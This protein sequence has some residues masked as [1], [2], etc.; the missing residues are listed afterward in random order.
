MPSSIPQFVFMTCRVGAEAALK[1]E[2]A[3]SVPDWRPAFSR[4][5][6]LTFK[7]AAGSRV[8]IDQLADRQWT[9]AHAQGI[10]L[11][12]LVGDQLQ[13]LVEQFWSQVGEHFSKLHLPS[14]SPEALGPFDLHVW[15]REPLHDAGE[16]PTH[17]TPLCLEIESAI[18]VA[19]PGTYALKGTQ[20]A[21]RRASPRNS[22]VLDVIV[23]EPNEWWIGYHRATRRAE[24]WPGGAIPVPLPDH[25][26]SRAYA[27]LEEAIQ[28]SN[29]PLANGELC[30]EIGCA[31]GGAS[32]ALLERG[33]SVIGI[34]PAE[35]APVV[36]GH[37][38]FRHLKKRGSD[39]RRREF[40][41]VRWLTADMNIAPEKTLDEV[42]AVVASPQAAI[43]GLILTLKLSEW[44]DAA[45]LPEFVGRVRG[46]GYRD[47]RTR[48]LVTGGQ[49]VCLV[50]L[51]RKA[52]RRL[53]K[54]RRRQAEARTEGGCAAVKPPAPAGG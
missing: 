5:G 15:Q 45:R 4:P 33:L 1:Q 51:R 53:G 37:P 24:R 13:G 30:V 54:L 20:P 21:P 7:I 8:D 26:V 44:A 29:L 40:T 35:V 34:D 19:A 25:A 48:Q 9:F 46:W 23:V 12:K 50:A 11:G 32:Q 43:R 14:S 10:C 49:E 42:E 6:F 2:V 27:K 3:R 52:L 47:V 36:A 28:W 22:L 17:V 38:R 16:L 39:V 41:G 31:P 18:R